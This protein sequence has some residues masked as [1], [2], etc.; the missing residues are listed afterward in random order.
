MVVEMCVRAC[1]KHVNRLREARRYQVNLNLDRSEYCLIDNKLT[2]TC[3]LLAVINIKHV[4]SW[5]NSVSN[6]ISYLIWNDVVVFYA[7]IWLC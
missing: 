2:S 6:I 1:M 4:T 5:N 3:L 7:P